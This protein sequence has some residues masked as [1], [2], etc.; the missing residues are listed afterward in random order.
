MCFLPSTKQNLVNRTPRKNNTA[1]KR[2][3]SNNS[4]TNFFLKIHIHMKA[5]KSINGFLFMVLMAIIIATIT[6]FNPF[7][8]GLVLFFASFTMPSTGVAMMAVTKEIWTQ[9]I[10]GKLFKNNEWAARAFNADM[11]VLMGKV[12]HIPVAGAPS[13][14][15][16]NV[17]VFPVAAVKRADTDVTYNIDTFYST[18]RHI[19]KIEQYELSYDKRQSALGEDQ[20]AIVESAMDSLLFRWAPLVA[21]TVL[22]DGAARLATISGATGNRKKFTKASLDAIKLLMDAA[23]IPA[24]DRIVVLTAYHYNDFLASLT[25]AERTDVGRVADLKTGMVGQYLG[26][27]IYMRSTVLRYRGADGAFVVVDEQDDAF[28]ANAIDRAASLVYQ[29]GCVERARGEVDIF[30]NTRNAEYYGDIYSMILR[31]GGRQRRAAGVYAVVE[32]ITA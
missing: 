16:K 22:T 32:A 18:P 17:T 10:I 28:V 7:V 14:I 26:F 21:N 2:L 23:D 31:L 5:L 15:K 4:T 27:T 9:D 12:V 29:A 24:N 19:E 1:L 30:E 11:Y 25:D 8:T 13:T 6:G 20:N 3:L